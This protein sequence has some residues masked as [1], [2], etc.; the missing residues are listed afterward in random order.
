MAD[1]IPPLS[2]L[3]PAYIAE[4]S[5]ANLHNGAIAFTVL[6]VVFVGLRYASKI[7]GRVPRGVDDLLVTVSLVCCVAMNAFCLGN[8]V[9][10]VYLPAAD[11]PPFQF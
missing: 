6:E 3:P 11:R 7:I 5:A 2:A 8:E 1:S 9:C 10:C 4:S